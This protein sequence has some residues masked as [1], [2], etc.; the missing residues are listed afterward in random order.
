MP[1]EAPTKRTLKTAEFWIGLI[2][3]GILAR[4]LD[5]IS[6]GWWFWILTTVAL[7]VP[8]ILLKD[9]ITGRM[10]NWR[11]AAKLEVI[12]PFG[13]TVVHASHELVDFLVGTIVLLPAVVI[14]IVVISNWR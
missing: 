6:D 1:D 13:R 5:A 10:R 7:F 12:G 8:S 2:L 3:G 9:W 4:S 14:S 11:D